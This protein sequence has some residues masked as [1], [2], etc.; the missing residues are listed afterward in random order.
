MSRWHLE[1]ALYLL[2]HVGPATR[3]DN[4]GEALDAL[5]ERVR[6]A[7]EEDQAYE[8]PVFRLTPEEKALIAEADI[9]KMYL[10]GVHPNLLRAFAGAWEL[11]MPAIYAA[12]GLK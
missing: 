2:G 1:R 4:P 6:L 11:D 3:Y 10:D 12:A 7:N 8:Y 5:I 9:V